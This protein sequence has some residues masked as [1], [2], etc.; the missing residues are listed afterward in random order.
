[1]MGT[2]LGMGVLCLI[3]C[4][5]GVLLVSISPAYRMHT[6]IFMVG[7]AIGIQGILIQ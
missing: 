1:M 6:E 5:F 2:R 7:M 4:D 3:L